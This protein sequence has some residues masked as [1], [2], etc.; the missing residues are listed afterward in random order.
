MVAK[1]PGG[2][3]VLE[4][5]SLTRHVSSP[6]SPNP[7]IQESSAQKGEPHAQPGPRHSRNSQCTRVA[8]VHRQA[9]AGSTCHAQRLDDRRRRH[10]TDFLTRPRR[11]AHYKDNLRSAIETAKPIVDEVMQSYDGMIR[12]IQESE[13]WRN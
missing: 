2:V 9:S 7:Q 5:R 3:F 4:L 10:T 8:A 6:Q 12:Q 1:V 13:G 11:M